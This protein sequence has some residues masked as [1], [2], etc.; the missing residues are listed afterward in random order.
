MHLNQHEAT[1][2]TYWL[3]E[4]K[5]LLHQLFF[6]V[7]GR[8]LN[9]FHFFVFF[10]VFFVS[11][12]REKHA[13]KPTRGE[14]YES[15]TR[16]NEVALA[17]TLFWCFWWVSQPIYFFFVFFVVFCEPSTHFWFL[18]SGLIVSH[19][20]KPTR[21]EA[22]ELLILDAENTVFPL[23]LFWSTEPN[24]WHLI[25]WR[26]ILN[27]WRRMMRDFIKLDYSTSSNA[28][29]TNNVTFSPFFYPSPEFH[30]IACVG[31]V[32]EIKIRI[33]VCSENSSFLHWAR[34]FDR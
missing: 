29:W 22:F 18:L 27:T 2:T 30:R 1:P 10:W 23:F 7:F 11:L 14:A 33:Q 16:E 20:S 26:L 4:R 17:P 21:G 24:H 12:T 19:S 6:D 25:M 31:D 5:S 8:F 15:L 28:R 3:E 9:P 32:I 34:L 13:S